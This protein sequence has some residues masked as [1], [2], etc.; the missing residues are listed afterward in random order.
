MIGIAD[1]P[2]AADWWC[3]L[4]AHSVVCGGAVE[5]GNGLIVEAE[6]DAQLSAMVDEMVEEHGSVEDRT[7]G[8]GDDLVAPRHLPVL[9]GSEIQSSVS[10]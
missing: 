2:F 7:R 1:F 6:V 8:V 3:W 5:R 10:A 4:E 9:L